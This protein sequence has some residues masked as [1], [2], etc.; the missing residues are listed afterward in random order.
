MWWNKTT[1]QLWDRWTC[2]I[3]KNISLCHSLC[4]I[5]LFYRN[6][7]GKK[8]FQWVKYLQFRAC[9]YFRWKIGQITLEITS[10][11]FYHKYNSPRKSEGAFILSPLHKATMKGGNVPT[12]SRAPPSGSCNCC[13]KTLPPPWLSTEPLL[14]SCLCP[15]LKDKSETETKT[16]FSGGL[17]WVNG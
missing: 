3:S 13:T 9:W 8:S 4:I 2:P 10:F 5:S 11:V 15:P 17:G 12:Q 7:M 16:L 14:W 1:A 6:P